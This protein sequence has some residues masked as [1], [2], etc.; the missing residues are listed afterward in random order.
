MKKVAK[1]AK[2]NTIAI[3]VLVFTVGLLISSCAS[4][5]KASVPSAWSSSFN[6]DNYNSAEVTST[7]HVIIQNETDIVVLDGKTGKVVYKDIKEKKGLLAQFG[8]QIKEQALS[9]IS[10]N[11]VDI[12]YW[13]LT[14]PESGVLL[15]FDRSTDYGDVISIDLETGRKL[16]Q[17]RHLSWNLNK[18][19]D[20]AGGIVDLA[21]KVSLGGAAATGIASEVLLQTRAIESMI[22]EVPEKQ[23]FLF[24]TADGVLHMIDSKRGG[25]LWQNS[26]ISSTGLGAVKYLKDSDDLLIAGD[27][28]NMKDIIKSIDSEETLKQLYRIDAETGNVIWST[29]YKGREDQVDKV[30]V[31]DQLALLYFTG[32]SL[33]LFEME[34][35]E[36]IF[37]TRDSFGMGTA[38]LA[39]TVSSQNTMETTETAMPILDRELVYA[40]NPTGEVNKFALDDKVITKFDSRTGDL[41]W[42]TKPLEKTIDITDMFVRD[43]LVIILIPGAGNVVGGAKSPGLY[44]FDKDTGEQ[45]WYFGD[46]Q[47]G[48]NYKPNFILKDDEI[49]TGGGDILYR[50]DLQNGSVISEYQFGEF[51]LGN[52]EE[53]KEISGDKYLIVGTKGVILSDNEGTP[54]FHE[55][56]DGRMVSWQ[57]NDRQLI[58]KSQKV[59][60]KKESLSAFDISDQKLITNFTLTGPGDFVY[61][62]LAQQGYIPIAELSQ[63]ITIQSNGITSYYLT[64]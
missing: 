38:R 37:G 11:D 48:K 22:E 50:I 28:G 16:W 14:L 54:L 4:T 55:T 39:S 13:H 43:E 5:K 63:V 64:R 59:L 9:G 1:G 58:A 61:G 41:V 23:A 20:I 24:R 47:L 51:G 56:L 44:A 12:K 29:K 25:S 30:F 2:K 3:G 52:I 57:M 42:K 62:N 36:R 49:L 40:V 33:E 7:D 34:S 19:E 46:Q 53:I 17:K 45:L 27:M 21:S 35:G 15:L 32:G 31:K 18:Y 6:W 26:D 10:G 60:S 8:D